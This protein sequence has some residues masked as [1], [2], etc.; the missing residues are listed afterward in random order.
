V[1]P[2]GDALRAW[3]S[4]YTR[5]SLALGAVSSR[6]RAC[7][8]CKLAASAVQQSG[9]ERR[10]LSFWF[11]SKVIHYLVVVAGAIVRAE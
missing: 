2:R 9:S 1:L 10:N 4:V 6:K 11:V 7:R 8:W 5:V 3:V